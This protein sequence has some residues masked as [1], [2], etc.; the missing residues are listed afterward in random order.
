MVQTESFVRRKTNDQEVIFHKPVI[1]NFIKRNNIRMQAHQRNRNQS[2]E[3]FREPLKQWH[4]STRDRLIRTSANTATFDAKWGSF[5]PEKKLNVDKML[6]P[7][8]FNTKRTY[9]LFEEGTNQHKEK[10]WISQPGSGLNK[11]Q[12]T[13]HT[14]F[15]LTAPHPKLA[16][17]FRGIDKRISDDEIQ[18]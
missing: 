7:F 15:C 13:L 2:K 4:A 5:M 3:S 14:C 18:M 1:V 12:C 17:T 16:I 8:A 6:C 9:H 10:V 11:R